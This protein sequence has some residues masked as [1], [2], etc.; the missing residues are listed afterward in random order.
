MVPE[1]PTTVH[2]ATRGQL[3]PKSPL[4][5]RGG[6]VCDVTP[7]SFVVMMAAF[8]DTATQAPGDGQLT[9]FSQLPLTWC[10]DQLVPSVELTI[11]PLLSTAVHAVVPAVQLIAWMSEGSF[12]CK[13]VQF[14][15]P[16]ALTRM[17]PVWGVMN[18]SD[19]PTR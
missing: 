2:A 7:P 14:V 17:A 11:L 12:E 18:A 19:D 15:P 4:P 10:T 13:C 8:I 3:A 6:A 16:S 9:P 1:S 5:V